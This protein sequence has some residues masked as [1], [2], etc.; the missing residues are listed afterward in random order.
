MKKSILKT[1]FLILLVLAIIVSS[2]FLI[3]RYGWK[4]GG[5]NACETAGIEQVNVE[6]DHVRIRG[7]YPGSFPRGFLGYHAEQEDNTLYVGFK[8]SGLF[9]IFE[10]GDFDVSIPVDGDITQVYLKSGTSEILIW[11]NLQEVTPGEPEDIDPTQTPTEEEEVPLQFTAKALN[12]LRP[13]FLPAL[14]VT[15]D[16]EI[17]VC[18]PDGNGEHTNLA[19]VDLQKDQVVTTAQLEG[20]WVLLEE[21]FSDGCV[22]LRSR[23]RNQWQFLSAGLED[24]GTFGVENVGGCFSRDRKIYYWLKDNI[25]FGTDV[26]SGE[27]QTIELSHDLRFTEI[28]TVHPTGDWIALRFLLSPYQSLCG[29][30]IVDLEA[31]TYILMTQERYQVD[32]LSEAPCLFQFDEQQMGYCVLYESGKQYRRVEAA[33]FRGDLQALSTSPYLLD[34]GEHTVL[35]RLSDTVLAC[36]LTD[37]GIEGALRSACWLAENRILTGV[38]YQQDG[39]RL[40]ALMPEQLPFAGQV[41]SELVESPM[42]VDTFLCQAYWD[43]LS[44]GPVG[45]TLSDARDYADRLEEKYGISIL[46]SNQCSGP[47]AYCN[48]PIT[49]TDNM[50]LTNEAYDIN[51]ALVGLDWTLSLYPQDFFSQFRNSVEEGGVRF[52]LVGHIDSGY[53]AIG[54]SFKSG[55]WHNIAIDVRLDTFESIVCHEVWHAIEDKIVSVDTDAFSRDV[56]SVCNPEGFEYY[57][58]ASLGDPDQNRWTLFSPGDEDTYFIDSYSRVNEKEDRARIMEYVMTKPEFA[59][60]IIESPAIMAKLRLMCVTIRENFDTSQWKDVLWEQYQDQ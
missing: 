52:L 44:G 59:Q 19:V 30:A 5:F 43:A 58:D 45:D 20:E 3:G 14:L 7:F 15:G 36:N 39:F 6:E 34:I 41:S 35:Y 57:G 48:Y 53:G 55:N 18:W 9:G 51:R 13:E 49:T 37:L 22:A 47:V 29:T 23:E 1:V 8:F 2:I 56:W 21:T 25:L 40:Y 60:Q 11:S 42:A 38:V 50:D 17:L 54:C 26:A 27:V 33:L 12:C 28:L 16:T 10:T 46:I 24:A 31:N 4:L 32:S